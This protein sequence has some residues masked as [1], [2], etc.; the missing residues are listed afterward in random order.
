MARSRLSLVGLVSGSGLAVALVSLGVATA[1]AKRSPVRQTLFADSRVT[2]VTVRGPADPDAV[3]HVV[4]ARY[5]SRDAWSRRIASGSFT[6]RTT[7]TLPGP[8]HLEHC[9]G[10]AQTADGR[11]TWAGNTSS[12]D[13]PLHTFKL[14]SGTGAYRG[15]RGTFVSRDLGPRESIILVTVTPRPGVTLRVGVIPRP[16]A[17]A[18]FI[19][20]AQR[21]CGRAA[22]TLAKLPPFPFR[23]FD[24]LHPD[25]NVLPQVGQ[26]FTGPGDPRPALRALDTRLRALGKP[27]ANRN[28]WRRVLRAQKAGV[29][30][31]DAQD[32]AALAD[33]VRAFVKTV[34]QADGVFRGVAITATLFGTT[35]CIL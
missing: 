3:G 11:F 6:C 34:R 14:T 23:D 22:R 32:R 10:S 8:E 17:N 5:L 13:A 4:I 33:D 1:G 27:P 7:K 19:R 28:W 25:P 15:A 24:P 18:P 16:A 20:R 29:A 35:R 9:T 30:V 26:F 2:Q 12:L 31:R 21:D